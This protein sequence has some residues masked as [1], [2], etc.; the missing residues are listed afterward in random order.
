MARVLLVDDE[1]DHTATLSRV[2]QAKGHEVET[3]PD[4]REALTRVI[5]DPPDVVVLDL[6]MP[7]MDG[8]AF[9]EVVRSYVRLQGL[10]VVV[11]TGIPD[12]PLA[13][14]T[15][16]AKVNAILAKGRANADEIDK[17]IQEALGASAA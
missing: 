12:S 5:S 17:A 1:P 15:K 8:A 11:L 2:L 16:S 9:V 3:A 6:L 10:P 13:E 14:R 4:G 7:E